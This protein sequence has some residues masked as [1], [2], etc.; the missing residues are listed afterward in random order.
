MTDR[1]TSTFSDPSF[2]QQVDLHY[3]AVENRVTDHEEREKDAEGA[4]HDLEEN[5][6]N[7]A[8]IAEEVARAALETELETAPLYELRDKGM[9]RRL[10]NNRGSKDLVEATEG[11]VIVPPTSD[12]VKKTPGK[13]TL[14][15]NSGLGLVLTKDGKLYGSVS[16]KGLKPVRERLTRVKRTGIERRTFIPKERDRWYHPPIP[17]ETLYPRYRAMENEGVP[18]LLGD[19]NNPEG[20]LD[21]PYMTPYVIEQCYDA[22]A[23]FV[24][25][26]DLAGHN[27]ENNTGAPAQPRPHTPEPPTELLEG[28]VPDSEDSETQPRLKEVE[29]LSDQEKI[30]QWLNEG[31]VALH[32][33]LGPN[34]LSRKHKEEYRSNQ[35]M[36]V[37][38]DMSRAAK[39]GS[40]LN[41]TIRTPELLEE[42]FRREGVDELLTFTRTNKKFGTINENSPRK[43]EDLIV[44]LY[45]VPIKSYLGKMRSG[46]VVRMRL[47]LPESEAQE[48]LDMIYAKPE[49]ANEIAERFMANFLQVGDSWDAA[50]PDFDQMRA[51]RGGI[52]RMAFRN[53]LIAKP[54]DSPI[55]EF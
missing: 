2:N 3:K 18:T 47:F 49:Q 29:T 19:L 28:S 8:T 22:L 15:D 41:A 45:E 43:D 6:E 48:A 23:R 7:L 55:K 21:S 9:V 16:W 4:L 39:L 32:T 34:E 53:S 35:F 36:T 42:A 38:N 24:Q 50:R 44:I 30:D 51:K 5:R 20:G 17:E 46:N 37:Y 26:N 52:R 27:E 12:I 31:L 13:A 54:E 11:W 40:E 14:T 25:E 33:W 1:E 10:M